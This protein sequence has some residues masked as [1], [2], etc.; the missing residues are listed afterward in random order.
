MKMWRIKAQL[1]CEETA[2]VE[3]ETAEEALKRYRTDPYLR[4]S[5]HEIVDVDEVQAQ[6]MDKDGKVFG[7][8]TT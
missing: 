1:M 2:V 6:E 7:P 5:R 3:A 8:V 4:N